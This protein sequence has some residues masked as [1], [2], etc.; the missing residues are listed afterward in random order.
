[1]YVDPITGCHTNDIESRWNACKSKFKARNGVPRE[2]LPG[3]LD[4]YMW[5]ARRPA[6]N[7]FGD[8]DEAIARQY[9]V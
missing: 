9:P 4:D 2:S 8:I 7:V 5:R 3:Y 6:E 1:M